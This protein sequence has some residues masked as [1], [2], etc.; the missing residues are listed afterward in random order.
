MTLSFLLEKEFKQMARNPIMVGIFIFFTL[1][2]IAVFPWVVNFDLKNVSIAVVCEDTGSEARQLIQKVQA[3]PT[4]AISDI[5]HTYPQ[6]MA[7]I[8]SGRA[9][10]ILHIPHDFS[11]RLVEEQASG[12]MLLANA[13]DASQASLA[14]GYLQELIMQ[15]ADDVRLDKLGYTAQDL[16]PI[17]VVPAYRFNPSLDYKNYM[18]P[19]FVVMLL[20]MF[21]GIFTAISIVA[22][23]EI[24]TL[25]QINVTP[26]KG[27]T[28]IL[29]K[30]IPFWIVGLVVLIFAVLF[31]QLVYGLSVAGPIWLLFLL[32]FAFIVTMT[33]FGVLISNIAE[34][35]QQAMFLILFFILILFLVSG[36]FT[37]VSN[38]PTWAQVIAYI[39]P[40]TYYIHGIRLI[41]LRGAGL[42]EVSR[43]LLTLVG[44]AILLAILA[45]LTYKKRY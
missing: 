13:V 4:F 34:T 42:M 5:Y 11:R 6:A 8:N 7:D 41:Y 36:L 25:Q 29:S 20:T 15:Y 24:G 19:A 1:L 28:Y 33:L 35:I 40:L 26:V 23:R 21:C 14:Q 10:L 3:S 12:V 27:F 44:Y 9:T 2:V 32:S 45:T 38:M 39:N 43:D 22:E 17:E 30:V 18:L 31:I 16:S 37:P